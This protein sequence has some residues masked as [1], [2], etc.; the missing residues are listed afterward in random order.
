MHGIVYWVVPLYNGLV[1]TKVSLDRA[2]RLVLPKSLRD[3]MHLSPGDDLLVENEGDRITLRP[4]R[5]ETLLKKEHG[6]W[7]YQ[8]ESSDLSITKLIDEE[9]E[10][11]LR[12]FAG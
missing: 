9:R 3:E 11:R 5:P 1:P 2:G 8:G 7:V 4:V 12:E 10:K 6:V